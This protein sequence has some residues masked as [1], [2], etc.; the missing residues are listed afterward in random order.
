MLNSRLLALSALVSFS[1]LDV[2]AV[3]AA[4]TKPTNTPP[5]IRVKAPRYLP[6]K[7]KVEAK[8]PEAKTENK[9]PEKFD[10]E[11][12]FDD[13]VK[14]MEVTKGLFTFYR[15]VDENKI[16]LEIATNQ[17]DKIFLFNSSIDRSVGERG[18]YSAQMA[19]GFPFTFRLVG[20]SVQMVMKNTLYTATNNTPQARST[21]RSFPSSMIGSAKILSRPHPDRKSLLINLSDIF[22]NDI[23]GFAR[24]LKATY[25]PTDYRF[26]KGNSAFG[27]VKSFSENVLIEAWLHYTTDNPRVGSLTLPDPRSI[28]IVVKYDISDLKETGYKPRLADDRVGHFLSVQADYSSDHPKS[29]MVRRINRWNLEKKEP[30]ASMSEPKKPIVY[31][32]ENTVPMEYRAAMTEG[33]LLWKSLRTHRFHQRPRRQTATGQRRLG[34]SG[35]ALQHDPLVRGRRRLVRHRPLARQSIHWRN[36]R[37]RHWFQRRHY[38]FRAPRRRRIH[39]GSSRR[40][41]SRQRRNRRAKTFMDERWPPLLRLR[42]RHGGTSRLRRRRVAGS[43]RALERDG[44]K[45]DA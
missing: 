42:F 20:K 9:K 22:L 10:D 3:P 35:H 11:K 34:P 31:W 21:E 39:R 33:V 14:N 37:R 45:I 4:S 41:A 28:P 7:K 36:L 24:D 23:P 17:F 32:L 6:A 8:K 25:T 16:Y 44:R 1:A 12:P 18:L 29:L 13:I 2:L 38:S 5:V 40:S 43:R 15:K 26:D 27:P 19:G 30:T